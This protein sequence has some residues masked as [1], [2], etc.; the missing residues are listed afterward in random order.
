MN[1]L[2]L[3][4]PEFLLF[5]AIVAI[6]TLGILALVRARRETA[7][8]GAMTKILDPYRIA[9]LRGGPDEAVKAAMV[10]LSERGL[11]KLE[12]E[13]IKAASD[14]NLSNSLERA[15]LN[16]FLEPK[17]PA[18]SYAIPA[19]D[20]VIEKYEK[21]LME[22]GLRPNA[23]QK[24]I[25]RRDFIIAAGV[26]LLLSLSKIFVAL[27]RG[28]TNILFLI[29]ITIGV[30]ILS[31]IVTNP[32]LTKFGEQTLD[33]LKSLF[34]HLRRSSGTR[35]PEE[36]VLLAAAFGVGVLPL[37]AY[38]AEMF[39][40]RQKSSS[41]VSRSSCGSSCGSSGGSSCGSSCG[42]GC[43]GGCGGCGS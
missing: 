33:D 41:G 19:A 8:A 42:G 26:L 12:D 6:G 10:S 9:Y 36:L 13:K 31:W 17:E 24:Q 3:R 22:A 34:G 2:D 32:R 5:Y 1:P 39:S 27:Q 29:G 4:G 20:S 11:L 7:P 23:A 35:S 30:V 37:H 18:F 14:Q 21:Q 16:H 40:P 25:R 43:G 28:R 38:P 15:V